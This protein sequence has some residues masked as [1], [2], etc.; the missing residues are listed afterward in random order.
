MLLLLLGLLLRLAKI[1]L[2]IGQIF[3]LFGLLGDGVCAEVVLCRS[4]NNVLLLQ[5]EHLLFETVQIVR[6]VLL[7]ELLLLLLDSCLLGG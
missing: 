4:I 1:F 6:L 5:A 7:M 2:H 3:L